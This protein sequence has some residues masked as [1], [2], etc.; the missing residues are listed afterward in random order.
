MVA[1]SVE[2]DESPTQ[3]VSRE[4]KQPNRVPFD[5]ATGPAELPHLAAHSDSSRQL[6]EQPALGG[7]WSPALLGPQA[8]GLAP[9]HLNPTARCECRRG[10][11]RA[12]RGRGDRHA[13]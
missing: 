11:N 5:L 3:F 2:F 13:L 7:A 9:P 1:C 10:G 6:A 8:D 12:E 4:Q